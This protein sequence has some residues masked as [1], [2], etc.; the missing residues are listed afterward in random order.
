[1]TIGEGVR[2]RLL[3]VSPLAAL[4]GTRVF[5]D[6]VPQNE[7]RPSVR[8]YVLGA[9][10]PSHKAG[11]VNH[12][13]NRVQ[14][15]SYVP[16]GGIDPLGEVKAIAAAVMGDGLGSSASG[17]AGWRGLVGGSPPDTIHI[18][19]VTVTNDGEDR[20][21]M[22]EQRRLRVRQEYVVHWRAAMVQA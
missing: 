14:V 13:A 10:R 7:K 11:P 22:E 8:V 4:V 17:L 3:G 9:L 15:D 18:F 21:E 5:E 1:M 12:F 6:L 19:D 2:E 16:I 20:V